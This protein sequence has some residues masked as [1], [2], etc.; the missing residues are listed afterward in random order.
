MPIIQGVYIDMEE[1]VASQMSPAVFVDT[2]AKITAQI[3]FTANGSIK[4]LKVFSLF[5][6]P[7]QDKMSSRNRMRRGRRGDSG[8]VARLPELS[9]RGC[10][11][12]RAY[13]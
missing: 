6:A 5:Y 8:K 1:F 10:F 3:S 9:R 12:K 11:L 7:E 13:A 4:S 2:K